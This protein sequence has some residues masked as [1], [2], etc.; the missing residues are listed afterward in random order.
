MKEHLFSQPFFFGGG[1]EIKQNTSIFTTVLRGGKIKKIYIYSRLLFWERKYIFLN[2]HYRFLGEKIK[3][4][5]FTTFGMER[6]FKKYFL[7]S[8]PFLGGE[9]IKR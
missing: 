4:F 5:F 9:K 8:R 2:F 7:Y 3:N 6:K 1:G